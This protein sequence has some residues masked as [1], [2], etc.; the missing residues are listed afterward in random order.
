M[1]GSAVT[2]RGRQG[3]GEM[4]KAMA[5]ERGEHGRLGVKT[6]WRGDLTGAEETGAAGRRRWHGM[7]GH[8]RSGADS[9]ALLRTTVVG[10]A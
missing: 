8:V 3:R 9:G 10:G 5:A 2:Y 6:R 4:V 1:H 7:L